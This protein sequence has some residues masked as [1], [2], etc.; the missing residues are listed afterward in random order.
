MGLHPISTPIVLI[1]WHVESTLFLAQAPF[2]TKRASFLWMKESYLERCDS[3]IEWCEVTCW[4][5]S[6]CEQRWAK[7]TLGYRSNRLP[8]PCYQ[9]DEARQRGHTQILTRQ[10]T[11][12]E[13]ELK[14]VSGNMTSHVICEKKVPKSQLMKCIYEC[15]ANLFIILVIITLLWHKT[16][17][18]R[19][20]QK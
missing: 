7:Q 13:I 20:M 11:D 15:I 18:T 1:P 6:N 8:P 16:Y 9:C 19:H 2:W 4:R 10:T 5:D 17:S 3:L 14:H 12:M